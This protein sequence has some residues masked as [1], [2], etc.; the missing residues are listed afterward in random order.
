MPNATITRAGM[1]MHV[2]ILP[3]CVLVKAIP[4]EPLVGL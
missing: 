4:S 1:Y 3:K 2:A